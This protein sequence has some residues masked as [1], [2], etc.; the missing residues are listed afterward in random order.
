[1]HFVRPD[2]YVTKEGRRMM[3]SGGMEEGEGTVL[4]DIQVKGVVLGKS[5]IL[6]HI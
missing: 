5:N 2:Q 4:M 3:E 1:M 6:K